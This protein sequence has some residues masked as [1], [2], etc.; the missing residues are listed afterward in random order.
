M[1][2]DSLTRGIFD[3]E[4]GFP[5]GNIVE[6]T[7]RIKRSKLPGGKAV[8]AIH[9]G[10][11]ETLNETYDLVLSWIKENGFQVDGDM[12]E[13]YLTDPCK[14]PDSSKWITEISFPVI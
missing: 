11:Y 10:P 9:I 7:G 12:W 3:M 14:I 2:Q 13:T 8:T 6:G 4:C 1:N 5:I